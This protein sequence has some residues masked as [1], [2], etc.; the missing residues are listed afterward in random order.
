[1]NDYLKIYTFNYEQCT[2]LYGMADMIPLIS[3]INP[4]NHPIKMPYQGINHY[5]N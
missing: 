4:D 3:K 1:M 5:A 2:T